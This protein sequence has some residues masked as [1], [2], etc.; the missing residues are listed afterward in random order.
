MIGMFLCFKCIF[1]MGSILGKFFFFL[2]FRL[3]FGLG[4]FNI[5]IKFGF[6][7]VYVFLVSFLY[8]FLGIGIG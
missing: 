1:I 2:I 4:E 5:V 6:I 8:K 7:N 3:V